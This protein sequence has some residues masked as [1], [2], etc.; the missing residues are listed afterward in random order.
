MTTD[1]DA[2]IAEVVRAARAAG[3]AVTIVPA[4]ATKAESLDIFADALRLPEWF[5]RN[6][7]ALADSLGEYAAALSGPTELVWD[8]VAEILA[9]EPRS[10]TALRAVLTEAESAHRDLHVTVVHRT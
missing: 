4:G 3:R 8:G 9:A 10:Y 7:D 1:T 2:P 6:L 5:G